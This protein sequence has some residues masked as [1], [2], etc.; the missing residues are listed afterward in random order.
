MV[1]SS[2]TDFTM[3][4][5]RRE[6]KLR[7]R[8]SMPITEEEQDVLRYLTAASSTNPHHPP[9]SKYNFENETTM[10]ENLSLEDLQQ[11]FKST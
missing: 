8:A 9:S 11:T 5:T 10:I 1:N 6:I 3:R 2:L 4:N 7:R